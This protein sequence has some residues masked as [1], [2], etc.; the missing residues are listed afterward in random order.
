MLRAL[1]RYETRINEGR[2]SRIATTMSS[3]PA[4]KKA[5]T[6][7]YTLLYHAGQIPGRGEY[8]RLVFEAAGVAFTEATSTKEG[9]KEV[10]DLLKPEANF[11][12]EGNP[13]PFAPPYLKVSGEGKNGGDL[14]IYQ[15]ENRHPSLRRS[16]VLSSRRTRIQVRIC[17]HS[18]L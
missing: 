14:L 6:P 5:K 10:Y 2:Y 1:K 3:E 17:K 13:P 15:T 9:T 18:T 4:T 12:S 7:E 8:V 16:V 11:D